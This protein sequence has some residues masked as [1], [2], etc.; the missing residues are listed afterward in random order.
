[1]RA[2]LFAVFGLA[3]SSA[4]GSSTKLLGHP[5]HQPIAIVVRVSDEVANND[6]GGA[7]AAMVDAMVDGLRQRGLDG[8]VYAAPDEHPPAPRIEVRVGTADPGSSERR[9]AGKLAAVG[10]ALG[11][12]PIVGFVGGVLWMSGAGS[13]QI[14][15]WVYEEG[16]SRPSF[17][18]SYSRTLLGD[19]KSAASAGESLGRAIMESVFRDSAP[20]ESPDPVPDE[21]PPI[22]ASKPLPPQGH[23]PPEA[24]KRVVREHYAAIERCY[25]AGLAENPAL[26]GHLRARFVI[27]T[28][29]D[30]A[31]I[32]NAGSNLP[33]PVA[34]C[35]LS[36]VAD[37]TFPK[38]EGGSVT[39]LYPF[40]LEPDS[41]S[42]GVPR[43]E[44]S[45]TVRS[46]SA[47]GPA[48]SSAPS[49]TAETKTASGRLPPDVIQRVVRD[50]YP[51]FRN[52]Y[53][54]GLTRNPNLKGRVSVAFVIGRDG[55]VTNVDDRGSDLPDPAVVRCVV[56]RFSS[57]IFPPPEGGIVTV[58]YPIML[59]PG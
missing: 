22:E 51:A 49:S 35:V 6:D 55:K 5:I 26:E 58:V 19:S 1:M 41:A 29:G 14:D 8:Q 33:D 47:S 40:V 52:C 2:R 37:M 43:S 36:E 45:K 13:V 44:A 48:S 50:H 46:A 3:L 34:R 4:C 28:D 27:D 21:V 39:V 32:D 24:I 16:R 20:T 15:C 53:E 30:V 18:E 23:L 11:R 59:E 38:P 10:G 9:G 12:A 25:A 42:D 31:S 54:A 57:L 7:V 56:S 17:H